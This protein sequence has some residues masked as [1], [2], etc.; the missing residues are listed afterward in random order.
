MEVIV[1]LILLL[2]ILFGVGYIYRRRIYKDVDRLEAWKIQI[3]NRSIIDELSKVKELKMVGQAEELFDQWRNE[4]DEIIT[5]QLPE[6]EELLFDAEDHSDKYRFKKARNVLGHVEKVLITVDE[7]I[8]KIIEEINELVSS[9][10]KNKVE[11]EEIKQQVKKV[12]KTLIA[13]SYQFGKA[14]GKLEEKLAEVSEGLKQFDSETEEGNYLA[15]REILLKV[16]KELEHLQ[17]KTNDIPKLLTECNITLPNLLNELEEGYKEMVGNGY[18]LEHIQVEI[19][20]DKINKQLEGYRKQLENAEIDDIAESLQAIQESIDTIYDLLEKEVESH[21][22]VKQAKESINHKLIELSEQNIATIEETNLV[23]QSY[24]LSNTEL[25][26]QKQIEKQ[27]SQIVK[28]FEHISQ[29]LQNDHIA[30]SII[31]DELGEIDK[32]ISQLLDDH[33]EYRDMLQTLRK[34]ELQARESLNNLKRVLLEASRAVHQSNIPGLPADFVELIDKAR[35]EVQKVTLK[36]D[37]IPLNMIV[38]NQLLEDA[39][40]T[41]ESLKQYADEIIEQV[42]LVEKVIQYGNRYRSQNSQLATKFR[43]AEEL[44]R[45]YEYSKSLDA[46]AAALEQIEPGSLSKIQEIIN[47]QKLK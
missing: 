26:R 39:V 25:D 19:E 36:L 18:Y 15:A 28:K 16:K 29:N 3:M 31:K 6:V 43:E 13:H 10:E 45:N 35:I 22:F 38:V 41:V 23:K 37:E 11:S 27:L 40:Q 46:A 17:V 33:N 4:W 8:D 34:D 14:H 32:Q 44:F 1:G 20:I 2:C 30:H 24:Q 21:Q 9:E 42:T 5:T 47:E 7:N 12:K